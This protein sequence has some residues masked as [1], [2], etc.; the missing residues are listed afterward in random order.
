MSELE[1]QKKQL[2]FEEI[3]PT[4]SLRISHWEE[5][6]LEQVE[7]DLSSSADC[8]VGEAWGNTRGYFNNGAT[9]KPNMCNECTKF[10]L[11]D[12]GLCG[13]IETGD[14]KKFEI[15]KEAFVKH[16]NEAHVK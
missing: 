9:I 5:Q 16:F 15:R 1:T 14:W 3:C 8:V 7:K 4:W 13:P 12:G 11:Y 6:N 10:A 2:T